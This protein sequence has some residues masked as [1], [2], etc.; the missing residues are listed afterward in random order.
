MPPLTVVEF[1]EDDFRV[2][3]FV[4]MGSRQLENAWEKVFEIRLIA[5]NEQ[6]INGVRL[7]V[8]GGQA[9]K[10]C[11]VK[12]LLIFW[13]VVAWASIGIV[14]KLVGRECGVQILDGNSKP[15]GSSTPSF[16]SRNC[17]TQ[18]ISPTAAGWEIVGVNA[19]FRQL[20]FRPGF[21][22]LDGSYASCCQHEPKGVSV[23][24]RIGSHHDVGWML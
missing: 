3:K 13:T 6:R 7:Q 24:F 18:A 17:C 20:C 16:Y 1:L 19:I 2:H 11:P 8:A 10:R 15:I 9:A 12:T 21:K 23:I 4:S 22:F 14:A 5:P